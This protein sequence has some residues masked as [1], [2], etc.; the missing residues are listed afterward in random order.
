M[1]MLCMRPPSFALR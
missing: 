1:S